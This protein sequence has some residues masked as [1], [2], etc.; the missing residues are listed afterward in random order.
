MAV[1]KMQIS[2]SNADSEDKAEMEKQTE[3]KGTMRKTKSIKPNVKP[4]EVK[5]SFIW[6]KNCI[7]NSVHLLKK[8]SVGVPL[9]K[10]VWLMVCIRWFPMMLCTHLSV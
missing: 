4:N 9:A 2:S 3:A 8:H 6:E 1:I 5:V 10:C 7:K